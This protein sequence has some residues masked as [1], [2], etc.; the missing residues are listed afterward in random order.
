MVPACL[1]VTASEGVESWAG[2]D[3]GSGGLLSSWLGTRLIS[4]ANTVPGLG[5]AAGVGPC[6]E[7]D[8]DSDLHYRRAAVAGHRGCAL[9]LY[10]MG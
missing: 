4:A 5:G 9:A 8:M 1:W 6:Y 7:Q 10:K 3:L 2:E